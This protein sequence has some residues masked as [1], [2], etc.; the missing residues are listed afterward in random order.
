MK[1]TPGPWKIDNTLDPEDEIT[2]IDH[3]GRTI[4]EVEEWNDGGNAKF[5]CRACNSHDDLVKACKL[6]LSN[7]AQRYGPNGYS[8]KFR[9][10]EI[11]MIRQAITKAEGK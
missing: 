3:H 2:I 9:K 5:I 10:S 11:E 7:H 1:H 6:V 4:A 8:I